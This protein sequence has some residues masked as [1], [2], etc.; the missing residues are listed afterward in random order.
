MGLQREQGAGRTSEG[1]NNSQII[2]D[3]MSIS[4]C[5]K[6]VCKPCFVLWSKNKSKRFE[7][8]TISSSSILVNTIDERFVYMDHGRQSDIDEVS[9][10]LVKT[11]FTS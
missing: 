3:E 8:K 11:E 4:P 10:L 9:R 6:W 5:N 1:V 2:E 7:N